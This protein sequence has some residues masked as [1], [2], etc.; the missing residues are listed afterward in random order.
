MDS[1]FFRPDK[2]F[3]LVCED[4]AGYQ[5]INYF[6]TEEEMMMEA[7]IISR[8]SRYTPYEAFEMKSVRDIELPRP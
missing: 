8:S 6:E 4:D 3:V 2:P 5:L 7:G 1:M